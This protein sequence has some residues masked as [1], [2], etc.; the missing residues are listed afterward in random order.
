MRWRNFVSTHFLAT[1]QNNPTITSSDGVPPELAVLG[2]QRALLAPVR[3]VGETGQ[4]GPPRVFAVL[5]VLTIVARF[6]AFECV[7]VILCQQLL[8][9][10]SL[11]FI[12]DLG[13]S[14]KEREM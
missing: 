1:P 13:K 2:F 10:N 6:S 4:T 3:P 14:E 7:G 11:S 5:I 8:N 12:H 9:K